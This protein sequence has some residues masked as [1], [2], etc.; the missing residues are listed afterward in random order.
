MPSVT[1]SVEADVATRSD[2]IAAGAGS[3]LPVGQYS[4]A[5]YRSAMRFPVPSGW[6][7]WTSITKAT[8]TFYISDHQHVAPKNSAIFCSRMTVATLWT[9][10]AGT[11]SCESGFSGSNNTQYD[12]IASSSGDRVSFNSGST[13]NAAKSI[14]VTAAVKTYWAGTPSTKIVFVFDNNGSDQYTEIWADE[15]SGY[16]RPDVK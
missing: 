7:G 2:G 11:Q 10:S 5:D 14:D 1:L 4:G 15:K 12:D 13:A 3:H 8:L 6:A 16:K 9:K